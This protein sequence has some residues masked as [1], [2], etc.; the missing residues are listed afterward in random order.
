M[1]EN[2]A[3]RACLEHQRPTEYEIALLRF[4]FDFNRSKSSST[5]TPLIKLDLPAGKEFLAYRLNNSMRRAS[6]VKR[7]GYEVIED[8]VRFGYLLKDTRMESKAIQSPRRRRKSRVAVSKIQTA[9][10][11]SPITECKTRLAEK[12]PA[13]A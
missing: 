9:E 6:M 4:I 13:V 3:S 10:R 8:A 7:E 12:R 5:S 2:R 11:E 1:A